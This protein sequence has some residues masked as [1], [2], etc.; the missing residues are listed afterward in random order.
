MK[1]R[2]VEICTGLLFFLVM[3]VMPVQAG[4]YQEYSVTLPQGIQG[5]ML[6]PRVEEQF[7]L[8]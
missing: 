6:E 7:R 1:I 8:C 2:D 3:F 4:E 5:I